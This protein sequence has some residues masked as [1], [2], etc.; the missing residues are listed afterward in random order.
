[1][2]FK[3]DN[4][5]IPRLNL[6]LKGSTQPALRGFDNSKILFH[7]P[8]WQL[9]TSNFKEK[10]NK[11]IDLL[12]DYPEEKTGTKDFFTNRHNINK[13]NVIP[14]FVNIL[15]NEIK[16]ISKEF[17]N[18]FAITDIWS[19]SYET[20]DYQ[21]PHNHGSTGMSAILYLDLPNNAPYTSYIQPWTDIKLDGTRTKTLEIDEGDIIFVPSF[22]LH[23]S[24]PNKSDSIKRIVSWD[25]KLLNA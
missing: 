14:K 8:F 18:D 2:K 1:M 23:F 17:Q 5:E 16:Q 20:G 9:K 25:I 22:L 21:S 12:K 24:E 4:E 13:E 15:S 7:I 19:V 6:N 11:I 3:N 10:K